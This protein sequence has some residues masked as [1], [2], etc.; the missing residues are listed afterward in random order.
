[1]AATS[2]VPAFAAHLQ[3]TL[4]SSAACSR[5]VHPTPATARPASKQDMHP[6]PRSPIRRLTAAPPS[7]LL[8]APSKR[9]NSYECTAVELYFGLHRCGE[10]LRSEIIILF[11][12]HRSPPHTFQKQNPT[13]I[14]AS[15]MPISPCTHNS[16][17]RSPAPRGPSPLL[18]SPLPLAAAFWSPHHRLAGPCSTWRR[19][20]AILNSLTQ[21]LAWAPTSMRRTMMCRTPTPPRPAPPSPHTPTAGSLEAW[22]MRVGVLAFSSL[23]HQ[24]LTHLRVHT[25]VLPPSKTHCPH[26]LPVF[27]PPIAAPAGVYLPAHCCRQQPMRCLQSPSAEGR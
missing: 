6:S 11:R 21:S 26:V 22:P 16:N 27:H 24:S 18:T 23:Q 7:P 5:A 14:H 3:Q 25:A 10:L 13:A 12:R 17:C 4:A 19:Q 20:L 8:R 2:T 1:M 15:P 9:R